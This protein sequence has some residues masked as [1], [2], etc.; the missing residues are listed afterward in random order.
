MIKL[1]S[2]ITLLQNSVLYITYVTKD[3]ST[4]Y[5]L[6]PVKVKCSRYRPG[7]AQRVGT[8]IIL[9]FHDRGTRRG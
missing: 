4:G 8:G 7:V 2:D 1:A 9:F 5:N 6:L 3:Q